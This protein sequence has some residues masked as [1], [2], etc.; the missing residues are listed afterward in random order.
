M[1]MR[2]LRLG[3]VCKD[4]ATQLEGTLTHWCMDMSKGVKYIFQ[5]QGLDN[6]G[7]PI[8]HLA[9]CE[10]RLVVTDDDFEIVDVPIE[11]LG[12]QVTHKASGFS[13]MA[14]EFIRHING[15]F[16]VAI[17]PAGTVKDKNTP[18]RVNE[19]DIRAC[20]GEMIVKMSP[21]EQKQREKDAPSPSGSGFTGALPTSI[22]ESFATAK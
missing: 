7:Q 4:K 8:S 15:C 13:G 21:E 1:E 18:I 14:T 11:I 5:P 19:F 2:I 6:E 17:Q 22:T 16:H 3:T 20:S 10:E 9:L 12:T